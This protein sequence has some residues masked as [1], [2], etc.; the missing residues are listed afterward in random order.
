MVEV[1]RGALGAVSARVLG[2]RTMERAVER[3]VELCSQ[4]RKRGRKVTVL[5]AV[6]PRPVSQLD[7]MATSVVA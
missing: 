1:E 5:A 6:M 3:I 4:K 2:R 7:Q